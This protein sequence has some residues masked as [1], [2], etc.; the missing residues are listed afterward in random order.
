MSQKTIVLQIA[1]IR[2]DL[3]YMKYYKSEELS[4]E[5]R[6]VPMDIDVEHEL[7]QLRNSAI[8]S[9]V[10]GTIISVSSKPSYD[11]INMCPTEE[12]TITYE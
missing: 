3:Q 1:Q 2:D 4:Y 10:D 7:K 9:S 6:A 5:R 8:S 12:V 11:E